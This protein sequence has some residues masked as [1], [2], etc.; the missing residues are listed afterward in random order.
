M[1][2]KTCRSHIPPHAL[3]EPSPTKIRPLAKYIGRNGA[4]RSYTRRD[5]Q[6]AVP[7]ATPCFKNLSEISSRTAADRPEDRRRKKRPKC[8]FYITDDRPSYRYFIARGYICL[9]NKRNAPGGR[10][11]LHNAGSKYARNI[12]LRVPRE[13]KNDI[14]KSKLLLRVNRAKKTGE[15]D[16]NGRGQQRARL[17]SAKTRRSDSSSGCTPSSVHP[18]YMHSC[19]DRRT[20]QQRYGPPSASSLAA[21]SRRPRPAKSG[22]RSRRF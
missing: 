5:A 8:N 22:S 19:I 20:Q 4:V 6:P 3:D 13:Q 2:I 10:V 17:Q 16:R 15:R 12:L 7:A 1:M 21:N 18:L 9:Y 14:P 11:V